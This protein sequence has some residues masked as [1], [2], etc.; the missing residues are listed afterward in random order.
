LNFRRWLVRDYD[1]V[2]GFEKKKELG[3]YVDPLNLP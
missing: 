2:K 3:K 1:E